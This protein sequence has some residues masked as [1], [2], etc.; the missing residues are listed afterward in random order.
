MASDVVT[1]SEDASEVLDHW[2]AR[3]VHPVIVLYILAVFAAF[4]VISHFIFHSQA[5][6]K[7]L[8]IAAVGAVIAT[9]PNLLGRIEYRL[10]ESGVEKRVLGRQS[11]LMFEKVFRWE[12]LSHVVP[13]RRGFKFFKQVPESSP[14]RRFWNLHISDRFSG[15][16]HAEKQDL[17]RVLGLVER[18]GITIS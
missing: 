6:V 7:A 16:V 9:L 15:E 4:I 5:A 2:S 17:Q 13:V 18:Q 12:E 14:L 10:T 8:V 3:R 11:P 1:P